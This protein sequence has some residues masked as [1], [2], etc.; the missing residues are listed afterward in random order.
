MA[1][2]LVVDDDVQL[3]RMVGMMLSRGGHTAVLEDNPEKGIEQIY[4]EE[5]DILVLDVMMPGM[6]GHDLCREIRATADISSLPI[7]ILTAR[8]QP[9]DRQAALESGADS[10]MS[11]PVIPDELL[12]QIDMLLA[13]ANERQSGMVISLFGLRGGVG[14]STLAVN[15]AASLRRNSE[16]EVALLDL[17][18]SV[19]QTVMHL[20]L[21]PHSSWDTLP[22]IAELAWPTLKEQLLVHP[23]GLRV[24]AAP[25]QPQLPL[26]PSGELTTAVLEILRS[27]MSFTVIDLPPLFNPAVQSALSLSDI[28]LHV[29]APEVI[30]VQ[31]AIQANSLLNQEEV[32]PKQK[33]YI[34]NQ[35]TSEPQLPTAAVSKG[36]KSPLAFRIDWDPNQM[37]A[38][39]QGVPLALTSAESP[40]A[41]A[42]HR[43]ARS[44]WE[45]FH[46]LPA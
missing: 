33:V 8:A 28:V 41:G 4:A 21:Q 27:Q 9:I 43:L 5:P 23:S 2:V 14:R 31:T 6:S 36:L 30:S 32:R 13:A 34:L 3:L 22:S 7:L 15:L 39:A 44:L 16:A 24:L 29:V 11:K 18:P 10:Y 19:G 46:P 37:Q 42:C 26:A 45:R 38:L 35:V 20:R 1:K 12:E 17:S 25:R 40:L